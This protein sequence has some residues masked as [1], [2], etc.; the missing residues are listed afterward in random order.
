VSADAL[1]HRISSLNDL[2]TLQVIELVA[3]QFDLPYVPWCWLVFGSEG[4]LEQTLATD[5]DNGLIFAADSDA[6]ASAC[7][8]PSYPLPERSMRR[9]MP[10]D[11]PCARA[12]SWPAIRSGV[13]PPT[14]GEQLSLA[15]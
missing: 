12:T 14:S 2:L 6:E 3:S 8:K 15:G 13:C 9:S 4:R 10:V 5:Q 11:F 1:C 7:A